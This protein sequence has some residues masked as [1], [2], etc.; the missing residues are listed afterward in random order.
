MPGSRVITPARNSDGPRWF[1]ANTRS[2]A[3][4]DGSNTEQTIKEI[5]AADAGNH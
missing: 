3:C 1:W 5:W 4:P 2:D